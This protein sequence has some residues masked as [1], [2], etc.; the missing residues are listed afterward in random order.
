[1][2]FDEPFTFL[3][4]FFILTGIALVLIPLFAKLIPEVD[5]A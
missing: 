2:D 5:F 1:M 4:I 3:G